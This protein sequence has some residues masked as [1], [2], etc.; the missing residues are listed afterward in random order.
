MVERI[1]DG[2]ECPSALFPRASLP[3]GHVYH[4]VIRASAASPPLPGQVVRVVVTSLLS[5]QSLRSRSLPRVPSVTGICPSFANLLTLPS[6]APQNGRWSVRIEESPLDDSFKILLQ[7][8]S[9][10]PL[11]VQPFP[12]VRGAP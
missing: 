7:I 6:I 8:H 10:S 5:P 4:Y 9:T 1:D 11:G 2:D 3:P 12:L